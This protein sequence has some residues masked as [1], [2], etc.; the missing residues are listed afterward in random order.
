MGWA[1]EDVGAADFRVAHVDGE[2]P[3]RFRGG[4]GP[5]ASPEWEQLGVC[6]VGEDVFWGGVDADRG[7]DDVFGHL[8]L[9]CFVVPDSEARLRRVRASG[10]SSA[11]TSLT[12]SR[13]SGR[14]EYIWRV[15]SRRSL[16]SPA[17]SSVFR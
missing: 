1:D 8:A 5:V 17:R 16:S 6:E 9:P 11:R 3:A 2:T 15:P 13:P 12:V 7:G 14:S 10:H 4:V